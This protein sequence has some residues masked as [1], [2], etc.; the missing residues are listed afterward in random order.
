MSETL[1]RLIEKGQ[2]ALKQ[3][4]YEEA[5]TH[6]EAAI[7]TQERAH[8]A[9]FGL[10]EVALG[11]GQLDT[12]AQFFEHAVQLQ[13]EVVLYQQRLGELYSHTGLAAEGIELLQ[14]ARRCAPRDASVLLSLAGAY[15]RA[16]NW[17]QAK[18]VLQSVFRRVKPLA[19]HY[20][21]LGLACQQLGE[22]DAA[23]E[24]FRKASVMDP[25]Y[26]DAWLSLGHLYLQKRQMSEA[27]RC[28]A[29]LTGLAPGL[30]TTLNLAGDI[31]L[32][33]QNYRDA[34]NFFRAALEKA[35]DSAALQVKLGIALVWCGNVLEAIDA[36]ENAHAAGAREDWVY[37]QLGLVFSTTGRL[38]TARENL[39]IAVEK[40]PDNLEAWNILINVYSRLGESEKARQAAETILARN[41][42]HVNALINLASW[43]GDQARNEEALALMQKARTL[44]PHRSIV[45]GNTLWI[46]VHASEITADDVL[47]MARVFDRNLY[48]D[49]R[50]ADDFRD[51][52]RDPDR[53][54]RVGWVSSDMNRHPVSM[55][56]LPCLA[57]LDRGTAVETFVYSSTRDADHVTE[58]LKARADTWRDVVALGDDALADL[59]RA[60]EIDIVVDLNG[61][62][63]GNRLM[64][65]ARKPAPIMVTW[66]GF[67]GTSGMSAMDYILVPPD[68]VLERPGWSS[69]APWP[70]PDCY[71]VRADL[72]EVA[73]EPGLPCE[74]TGK[75]FT[76]ACFNNFRKV[77]RKVIELWSRIL[78]RVP[79]ARLILVAKGGRDSVMT[80]YVREQF[81]QHGVDPARLE[82]RGYCPQAE[83]LAS[84]N[85]AD[86]C[87]DPFPFN[88]GTTGYDAIWMGVPFITLP[89]D[90][91]VSRMGK[92]ILENAG[93]SELVAPDADAYVELAVALAQDRARLK[94][95]RENLRERMRAS[96]LM[97][98]PRMAR[99][100]EGAFRG[101]WRRWLDGQAAETGPRQ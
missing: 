42:E 26:P 9:W 56:V 10:G 100:L 22:L 82:V 80:G 1:K 12:A 83:Y 21:L 98:A 23:R 70:L 84:H 35:A 93:L 87:L 69:E 6:F 53:R 32:E 88:G 47:E 2:K 14:R 28:L 18:A 20:C 94:A 19:A 8:Q 11:I 97:D 4:K 52:D 62:T 29:R 45:Y 95:L 74:R 79:E 60:D 96:P 5:S 38:Q 68:P 46:M 81:G 72:P 61:N 65:L 15:A 44:A 41:P 57:H 55:F 92:A 48:R 76:F 27:E 17:H 75:P 25:R 39:E 37:E 64:A 30:P 59:I 50:R 33:R 54:L 34:A 13:P 91:L 3:K 40:S 24:A 85:V 99:S 31:A 89:G 77:S 71:G 36:L 73:I 51:R 49:L 101:M 67:P 58:R 86:L 7:G 66:L 16:G 90:M 63:E 43:Y 78:V